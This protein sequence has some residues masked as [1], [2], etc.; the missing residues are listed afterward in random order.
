M[1]ASTSGPTLAAILDLIDA[2][3]ELLPQAWTASLMA[4]KVG[5]R[6]GTPD[7]VPII[8]WSGAV[9]NLMYATG[10]T[11][12]GILL[13]PLTAELVAKRCPRRSYRSDAR[14]DAAATIRRT[15]R[16]N[17]SRPKESHEHAF[18]RGDARR[19]QALSGWTLDGNAI[20]KQFTFRDFPEAVHFVDRL[21]PIA[22]AADHHPTS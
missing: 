9:P 7:E 3:C 17:D 21:V 12:T 16:G 4:A 2:V 6:P 18:T 20:K 15:L 22:E 5:L 13:A 14:A 1:P 10:H 11:G 8:G 19:L